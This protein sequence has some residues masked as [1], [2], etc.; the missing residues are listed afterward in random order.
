MDSAIPEYPVLFSKFSNALIGPEDGIEKS[1][2]TNQLDY[3][4]ELVVVIG[5]EASQV[6]QSE[7]HNYIAGYTIG[8]DVTARDMQNRTSQWLQG[9]SIDRST[10][11]G[12]WVVT[13][14]ER[15]NTENFSIV[16]DINGEQRQAST[17]NKFIFNIAL[18]IE[19][20]SHLI[21][22]Q[23]GD[24]ILTGT[25]D[26]VDVAMNPPQFLVDHDQIILGT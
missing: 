6:S 8:N 14:G 23:P 18:L 26:G 21:T 25:A 16:C 9:K 22:L 11:I 4:V 20:I 17:T 19:Y 12:P 2:Q 15:V 7:A 5:R 3:E 24:I 10:P 13:S 1:P